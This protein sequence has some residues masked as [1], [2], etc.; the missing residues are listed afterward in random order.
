MKSSQHL[1]SAL[2][3]FK[4]ICSN[5]KFGLC[6]TK[7]IITSPNLFYAVSCIEEYI[8][9]LSLKVM[10]WCFI[11]HTCECP[12]GRGYRCSQP[13]SRMTRCYQ[14]WSTTDTET[15]EWLLQSVATTT[16]FLQN[17]AS[18]SSPRGLNQRESKWEKRERKA[19][20]LGDKMDTAAFL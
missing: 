1:Q 9:E 19:S 13:G 11:V 18:P 12:T 14:L 2:I 4:T 8:S 3:F 7:G 10:F 17:P 15:H 5:T 16:G 20:V 6:D